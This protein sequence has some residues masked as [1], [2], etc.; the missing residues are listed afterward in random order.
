MLRG[1]DELLDQGICHKLQVK[2]G[3]TTADGEFTVIPSRMFGCM[4]QSPH[5]LAD[6]KVIG[7]VNE[8]DLDRILRRN[9]KRTGTSLPCQYKEANHG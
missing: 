6:D 7:P 1:A 3:E 8:E 2:P 4:R 5:D 9:K